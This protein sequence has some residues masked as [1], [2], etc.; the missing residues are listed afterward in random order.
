MEIFETPFLE[1][2]GM[3]AMVKYIV[4]TT[5]YHEKGLRPPEEMQD[6]MRKNVKPLSP[7]EDVFW[8][9]MDDNHHQSIT[10]YSSEDAAKKH[11]LELEEFRNNSSSEYT[12]KMVEETMGLVIAQ[13]SEL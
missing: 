3:N 2:I 13:M 8:W 10:I 1:M 4:Y 11:R 12:I 9:K 7:A 6:G 5:W